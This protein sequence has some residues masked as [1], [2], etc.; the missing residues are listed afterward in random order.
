MWA[1]ADRQ[2][3]SCAK[4]GDALGQY[5]CRP[6]ALRAEGADLEA[7]RM[8]LAIGGCLREEQ[9]TLLVA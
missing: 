9:E 7:M 4:D 8:S 3:A 2:M 6:P 1:A 5:F